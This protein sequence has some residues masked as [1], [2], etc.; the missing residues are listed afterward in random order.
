MRLNYNVLEIESFRSLC[1]RFCHILDSNCVIPDNQ[2]NR[3]SAM[4]IVYNIFAY[5]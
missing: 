3:N 2:E 1:P 4:L 5:I